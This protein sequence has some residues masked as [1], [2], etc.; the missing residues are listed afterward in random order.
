MNGRDRE[1]K[2]IRVCIQNTYGAVDHFE[3]IW[4]LVRLLSYIG[5]G[6]NIELI[7]QAITK[8]N[9]LRCYNSDYQGEVCE[10]LDREPT[11]CDGL[12]PHAGT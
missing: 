11:G 2:D 6:K 8:R 3:F 4:R 7:S 9:E 5:G 1:G 12:K 10:G